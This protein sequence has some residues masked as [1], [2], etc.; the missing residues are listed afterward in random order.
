MVPRVTHLLAMFDDRRRLRDRLFLS[1]GAVRPSHPV[2][3]AGGGEHVSLIFL[4]LLS[5]HDVRFV[6][7]QEGSVLARRRGLFVNG[8]VT[9]TEWRHERVVVG[10]RLSQATCIKLLELT[11]AAEVAPA[12]HDVSPGSGR[13]CGGGVILDATDAHGLEAFIDL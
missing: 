11:D 8:V 13:S 3:L 7:E 10:T 5:W 9:L 6:K 4:L 2:L 1:L 12:G